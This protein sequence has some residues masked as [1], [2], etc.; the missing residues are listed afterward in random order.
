MAEETIEGGGR[1]MDEWMREERCGSVAFL[2]PRRAAERRAGGGPGR[3]ASGAGDTAPCYCCYSERDDQITNNPPGFLF[4][5]TSK[6]FY[7]FFLFLFKTSSVLGIY[8]RY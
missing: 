4:P 6:S 2:S 8:L 7:C 3:R 5:F 1:G